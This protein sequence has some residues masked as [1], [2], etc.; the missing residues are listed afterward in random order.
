[1][2]GTSFDA[3]GFFSLIS[4]VGLQL[5]HITRHFSV[6]VEK[7]MEFLGAKKKLDE[8]VADMNKRNQL[9]EN[10]FVSAR[11]ENL[12]FSYQIEKCDIEKLVHIN[13]PLFELNKGDITCIYGESG[14]G[15]TTLLH[16]L[17]GE[18]QISGAKNSAVA[19]IPAALLSKNKSTIYNVPEISDINY[20]LQIME[21]LGCKIEKDGDTLHIDS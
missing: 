4:V 6:T 3:V 19:L 9:D 17:S 11:I 12:N 8:V 20:L 7:N 18:I 2:R 15:K 5:V 14:Q 10:D 13:I 21:L 16:I 1:M